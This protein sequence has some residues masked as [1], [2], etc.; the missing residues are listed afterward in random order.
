LS[1]RCRAFIGM[2][3]ATESTRAAE[4]TGTP[5]RAV[6]RGARRTQSLRFFFFPI[7]TPIAPTTGA[8]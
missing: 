7:S 1:A 4:Y 6:D 8:P 5:W 2:L 3:R